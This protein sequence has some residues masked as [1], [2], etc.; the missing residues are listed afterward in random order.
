MELA[1]FL[2]KNQMLQLQ[3]QAVT[4]TPKIPQ[5]PKWVVGTSAGYHC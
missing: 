3:I 1:N 4:L 5:N 2:D